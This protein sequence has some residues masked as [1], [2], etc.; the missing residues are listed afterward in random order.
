[1]ILSAIVLGNS[2]GLVQSL[3]MIL[4]VGICLGLVY[5]F[6]K[7]FLGQIGAPGIALTIWTGLFILILLIVVIN[8]LL[9]LGGHGFINY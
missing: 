5:W 7:W 9:G 6:G 8:F 3:L 2:G 4:I 1:M